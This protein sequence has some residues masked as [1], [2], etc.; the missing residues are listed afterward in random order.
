MKGASLWCKRRLEFKSGAV[1]F[2]TRSDNTG[3]MRIVR[4]RSVVAS[5]NIH[6]GTRNPH[7]LLL[8][9]CAPALSR[10]VEPSPQSLRFALRGDSAHD[11]GENFLAAFGGY[12]RAQ[13]T[14]ADLDTAFEAW[15]AHRASFAQA[16]DSE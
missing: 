3:E 1:T 14:L 7:G 5:G 16:K 2:A 8:L 6:A 15:L 13:W 12:H 10:Q 9:H 4:V 11:H